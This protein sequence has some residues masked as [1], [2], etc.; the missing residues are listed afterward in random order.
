MHALQELRTPLHLA[1]ARPFPATRIGNSA[2]DLRLVE[3]DLLRR[4]QIHQAG[5]PLGL[6][7]FTDLTLHRRG[8]RAGARRDI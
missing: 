3:C 2:A 1:G 5:Q 8:G 6:R 4:E 7:L